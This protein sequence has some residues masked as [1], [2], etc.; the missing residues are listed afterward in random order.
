MTLASVLVPA[1]TSAYKVRSISRRYI[2][3]ASAR[4]LELK[5]AAVGARG[6]ALIADMICDMEIYMHA[7]AERV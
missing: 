7:D 6:A 5:V 2:A 4:E 1:Y 3:R